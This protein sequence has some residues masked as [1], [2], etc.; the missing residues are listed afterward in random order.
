LIHDSAN[1]GRFRIWSEIISQYWNNY[2]DI[3]SLV[4]ISGMEHRTFNSH[5]A[6]L[7]S[8]VVINTNL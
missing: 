3:K 8:D 5:G 1:A 7:L 4:L 2:G 6:G